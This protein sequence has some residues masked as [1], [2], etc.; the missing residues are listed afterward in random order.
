MKKYR[1]YDAT[2]YKVDIG[3]EVK[4][5]LIIGVKN[6][7]PNQENDECNL[8]YQDQNNVSGAISAGV[9]PNSL[10]FLFLFFFLCLVIR[11]S[12]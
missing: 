6:G 8:H 3:R 2:D 4:I 7:T 10:F 1:A 11:C 5:D 9:Y 12:V